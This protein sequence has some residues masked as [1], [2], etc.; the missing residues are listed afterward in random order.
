MTHA[1]PDDAAAYVFE[2]L[3][4]LPVALVQFKA[5]EYVIE[6]VDEFVC[7]QI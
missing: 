2:N 6:E 7:I 1:L 3:K 5:C 4:W